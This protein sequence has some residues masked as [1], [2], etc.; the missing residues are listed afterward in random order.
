MAVYHL[1]LRHFP[2]L[3]E[4]RP[5]DPMVGEEEKTALVGEVTMLALAEAEEEV[6]A[7]WTTEGLAYPLASGEE[8][9]HHLIESGSG[10]GSGSQAS[11]GEDGAETLEMIGVVGAGAGDGGSQDTCTDLTR[12]LVLQYTVIGPPYHAE[13]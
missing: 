4:D 11:A 8:E 10:S 1:R 13:A 7:G 12:Y 2:D 6:G 5:R 3:A 9:R